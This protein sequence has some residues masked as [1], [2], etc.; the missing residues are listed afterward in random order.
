M[1]AQSPAA[2]GPAPGVQF[3]SLVPRLIGYIIDELIVGGA[4]VVVIVVLAQ[5]TS[6]AGENG[7]GLIAG[8]SIIASILI[9][10][11]L[12]F[13]YFPWLW[14]H[15]GQTIGGKVVGIRVVS[16]EDGSPIGFLAG[17][18]RLI[19]YWVCQAVFFIG[20]LWAIIDK[21]K[22]G[23]HDLIAGTCVIKA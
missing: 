9:V 1:A 18:A 4:S 21:R 14:S 7:R 13:I 23:W 11:A 2:D 19:G 16:D 10:L 17:I 12:W 5:V 22:R 8:L 15:G 6:A 3:A 20:F